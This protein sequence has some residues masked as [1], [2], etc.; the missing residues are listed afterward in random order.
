M[1]V[2]ASALA[3][4]AGV[5]ALV[6]F[7]SGPVRAAN[8]GEVGEQLIKLMQAG[9]SVISAHQELIN[10]PKKGNKGFTADYMGDKMMDKYKEM[11]KIDLRQPNSTPHGKVLMALVDS[12]KEVIAEYQPVIN[13]QGI[14]FK[15]LIPAVFGRKA[16]ERFS[17]KTGIKLKLTAV[18]YRFPG[19]KPDDFENEVLKMFS[20]P[21]YPKGKDYSRTVMYEGRPAFR[22]MSPE[23]AGAS[24]LKCHGEPRGDKDITGNKK[25][26]LKEGGLAGAISLVIPIH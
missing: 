4:V 8:E 26:G 11:T 14:A 12:G 24:C 10:D 7:L 13:K 16:G 6:L 2:T 5:F 18:D 21:G 23:Y 15:G 1:K 19:N 9:R 20:D 17:Q 25:E 3:F 22:V